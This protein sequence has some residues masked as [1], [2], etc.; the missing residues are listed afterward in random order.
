MKIFDTIVYFLFFTM[1]IVTF[2]V[3]SKIK[4]NQDEFRITYKTIQAQVNTN[5]SLLNQRTYILNSIE[6]R[7]KKIP[8]NAKNQ[9]L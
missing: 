6:Q 1:L 5:T 2:N 7:L 4:Q 8:T 9:T 3:V